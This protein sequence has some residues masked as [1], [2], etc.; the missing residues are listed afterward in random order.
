[1]SAKGYRTPLLSSPHLLHSLS[2]S[3]TLAVVA[4][5]GGVSISKSIHRYGSRGTGRDA[6]MGAPRQIG[7]VR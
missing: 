3:P 1:M 5:S 7:G 4:V 2:I 6:W